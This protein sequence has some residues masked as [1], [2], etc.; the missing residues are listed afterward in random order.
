MRYNRCLCFAIACAGVVVSLPVRAQE[1]TFM[2]AATHPGKN[3]F[4]ARILLGQWQESIAGE[5]RQ[6]YRDLLF[7]A[8]YGLHARLALLLDVE[9]LT[10]AGNEPR[11]S[12]I[13][14]ASLRLK[15]RYLQYDLGPVNTVRASLTAGI[16]I[17]GREELH[18]EDQA[19]PRFGTAVTAILGRH[20]LNGQLDREERPNQASRTACNIS[21]LYRI[22]P[23][24]YTQHTKGAWYTMLESLNRFDDCG[25]YQ[26][27]TGI[28]ILYEAQRWAAEVAI[29]LPVDAHGYDRHALLRVGLRYLL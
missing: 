23:A 17:P 15:Y 13:A 5:Q 1:P 7:K 9:G 25:D 20:G 8:S 12:G 14:Q 28:G 16:V 21:H 10:V 2:E 22:A 26:I 6:T 24:L 4:Y 29:R 11:T 19:Y 27:D 3:Q 18:D